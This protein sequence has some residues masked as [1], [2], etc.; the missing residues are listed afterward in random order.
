[1]RG[2]RLTAEQLAAEAAEVTA[3]QARLRVEHAALQRELWPEHLARC[4]LPERARTAILAGHK[5]TLAVEGVE[6]FIASGRAFCALAGV[7]GAGKTV[8]AGLLLRL[9]KREATRYE[10]PLEEWDSSAGLYVRLSRLERLSD[11]DEA[12]KDFWARACRARV[13]ILDEVGFRPGESMSQRTQSR[14]DELIDARDSDRQKTVL[15]S[16]LSFRPGDGEEVGQLQRF[17]GERAVSRLTRSCVLQDCGTED[18][19]R[20]VEGGGPLKVVRP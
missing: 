18:L 7:P 8:A 6:R 5:R 13:V 12:D 11:Y 20:Q 14:F 17:V 19:R 1:M 16:N 4:G 2:E 15:C 3:R 9:A 10:I